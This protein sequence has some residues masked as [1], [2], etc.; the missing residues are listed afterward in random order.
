SDALFNF[1]FACGVAGTLP[2]GV[3][4]AMNGTVFAWNK[5]RKNRLAG[6]FEA[7]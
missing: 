4:V 6:R 1:G 7:I 2:A 5:V 3:Y